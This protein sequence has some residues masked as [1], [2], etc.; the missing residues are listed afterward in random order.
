[1]TAV[2]AAEPRNES[3]L[4]ARVIMLAWRLGLKAFHSGI[5]W[6]D[7]GAGFP[8]LVLVGRRGVLFAELKSADGRLSEDQRTWRDRLLAAGQEWRLWRP[9][10]LASGLIEED[11]QRLAA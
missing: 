11:L 9:A 4:L 6:G 7:T 5:T 2:T 1:V 10:D 8:D 3:E